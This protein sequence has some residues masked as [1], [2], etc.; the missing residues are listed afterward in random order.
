[1]PKSIQQVQQELVDEFQSLND[2]TER[3][4]YII[5]L[6]RAL[7]AFPEE[8]RDEE[9]KVQGCQS[10]VW[11]VKNFEHG[12]IFLQATSDAAIVCGI[13]AILLRIYNGRT[14]QEILST[15]PTFIQVLGLDKHLSINRSNGLYSILKQIQN[16]AEEN[17]EL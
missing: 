2:W 5:E 11:L 16:Y 13:I 15:P 3:Y 6:G 14:P 12:K 9:H 1:M 4:Q 17:Y 10:Q 7:P 8:F